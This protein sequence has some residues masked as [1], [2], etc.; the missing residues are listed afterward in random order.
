[1]VTTA[2]PAH[3]DLS[4]LL[5]QGD[6]GRELYTCILLAM[7]GGATWVE[8]SGSLFLF[9][10]A[11][12]AARAK[13]P[14]VPGK[15]YRGR[16]VPAGDRYVVYWHPDEPSINIDALPNPLSDTVEGR[17]AAWEMETREL[18]GWQTS[19][20]GHYFIWPIDEFERGVSVDNAHPNRQRAAVD[21]VLHKYAND[22]RW[23][24]LIAPLLEVD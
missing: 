16:D 8:L 12:A 7:I 14:I 24:P 10:S 21:A 23:A 18:C 11:A 4:P 9:S 15:L 5:D 20:G 17:A 1:M 19:S 22:P 13:E 2:A 6:E 3:P